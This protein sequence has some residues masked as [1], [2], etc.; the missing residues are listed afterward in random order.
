[1][2]RLR[3]DSE[4]ES[5]IYR[6]EADEI[7][8]GR[9]RDCAIPLLDPAVARAHFRIV[10]HAGRYRVETF[11]DRA[12]L[13]LNGRETRAAWLGVGDRL[14]LGGTRIV[15]EAI[16]ASPSPAPEPEPAP[17][18]AS[19]AAPDAGGPAGAGAAAEALESERLR[20]LLELNQS[21]LEERD[22]KRLLETIMDTAIELL[23]AERGFLILQEGDE[24]TFRVARHFEGRGVE[25]PELEISRSIARR[26]LESGENV[27]TDDA[28][29]DE[30]FENLQSVALL[31]LRSILCVC[32]RTR[33]EV[34][35]ALYLDNRFERGTFE[36]ADMAL[37]KAF[38]DQAA[39]AIVN[40]RLHR[41][42]ARKRQ[43][44]RR[45]AERI[46][47]L[48][49]RLQTTL[50]HR[51][52]ELE[53]ARQELARSTSELSLRYAYDQIVGRSPGM[54]HVLRLADRVT[55]LAV[56]VLITGA[57]G[58][59]KELLARAIHYNG[60]RRE[61]RFVTENCAAIPDTLL[62]S[63][64]FG[65]MKGAFTGAERD[66]PGLFELARGGTLF[67]DEVG[68][69]SPQMQKKILRALQEGEVRRVGGTESI[70]VDFR[71]ITATNRDLEAMRE[72]GSFREDLYYRL[73]VVRIDLPPLAERRDDLPELV[74][75]FLAVAAA[76]S[77]RP[78]PRIAPEALEALTA[79]DWP[80]NVRQLGNEIRRACALADEEVDLAVLSPVVR[81]GPG[82]SPGVD[83]IPADAPLREHVEALER[84]LI[85]E[86][87][88]ATD[89]NKTHAAERLG[90]SRLGLRKKIERYGL[91]AT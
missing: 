75:H 78:K 61:A 59:G 91:D 82:G 1:M 10:K 46:A 79:Y 45:S 29:A 9:G 51:T 52:D 17:G 84:R 13:S 27:L 5:K 11:D 76:E 23:N 39:L 43:A 72:D 56:P 60:P 2:L 70:R 68:D 83:G 89:G 20:K 7:V 55:D 71:L 65:H 73:N 37:A 44:L 19:A 47:R 15:L 57:S 80:G 6:I 85:I 62:E 31:D 12:K 63:E 42:N 86:S 49:E 53:S 74:E 58:T 48:N 25:R 69:M 90:L 26:V 28:V 30:R 16:L 77:A 21:L 32:L 8:V 4:R 18:A 81:A 33:R 40:A 14:T 88:A 35:G 54:R 34:V 22:P 87:L 64:L 66:A 67:L 50:R 3:V 24:L 38:A 36:D 41:E